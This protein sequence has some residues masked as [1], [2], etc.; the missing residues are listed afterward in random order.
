MLKV[1]TLAWKAKN[2]EFQVPFQAK[3][4]FIEIII[5]STSPKTMVNNH[6]M[7]ID[8]VCGQHNDPIAGF[9]SLNLYYRSIATIVICDYG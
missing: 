3:K 5:I 9:A 7:S 6:Q 2:P 1:S 8:M 4:N